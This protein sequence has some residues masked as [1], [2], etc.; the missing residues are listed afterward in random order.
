MGAG[1]VH[2]IITTITTPSLTTG[3][4]TKT[5]IL[6]PTTAAGTT[7]LTTRTM[8]PTMGGIVHIMEDTGT[9]K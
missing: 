8:A 3:I 6:P 5:G 7:I 9:R 2:T 1:I 4:H